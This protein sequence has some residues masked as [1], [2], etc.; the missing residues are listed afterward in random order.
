M[1]YYDEYLPII[2]AISEEQFLKS[3]HYAAGT[4]MRN[5]W[6]L[7]WFEG[8]SHSSWPTEKPALVQ[9]FNDWGIMDADDM[10]SEILRA[11]WKKVQGETFTLI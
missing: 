9:W 1:A 2:K 8:H 11:L 7:F 10:S 3:A 4:F 6:C 5:S